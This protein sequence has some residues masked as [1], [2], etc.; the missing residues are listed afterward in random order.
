MND[1]EFLD[2]RGV[3]ALLESL[4]I[5]ISKKGLD[6]MFTDRIIPVFHFHGKLRIRKNVLLKHLDRLQKQAEQGARDDKRK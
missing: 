3:G 2:K 5:V 4:G 1:S 6:R